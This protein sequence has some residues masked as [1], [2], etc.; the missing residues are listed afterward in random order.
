MCIFIL[1]LYCNVRFDNKDILNVKNGG[2][3][4]WPIYN[5]PCMGGLQNG[6]LATP[7]RGGLQNG[8]ITPPHVWGSVKWPIYPPPMRGGLQ[9]GQ[10]TTHPCVGVCK[11]ANL[12]R[13]CVG[14]LQNTRKGGF[15]FLL[16]GGY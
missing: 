16:P 13:P 3:A 2:S 10:L 6:Q 12:Q 11:M 8:Q 9:D 1:I 4:K 5:P 15:I 14:G 7:M